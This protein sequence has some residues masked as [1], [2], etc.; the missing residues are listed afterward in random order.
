MADTVKVNV[1][2]SIQDEPRLSRGLVEE[3]A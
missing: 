3:S 1:G 2:G